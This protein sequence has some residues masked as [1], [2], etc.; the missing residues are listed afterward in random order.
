MQPVLPASFW[1]LF[2]RL[3]F[4]MLI[5]L[6]A[7]QYL[8]QRAARTLILACKCGWEHFVDSFSLTVYYIENSC[9]SKA[10]E[11]LINNWYVAKYF[12][13]VHYSM[14]IHTLSCEN[15]KNKLFCPSKYLTLHTFLSLEPFLQ[16]YCYR[17]IEFL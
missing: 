1:V 17:V 15:G 14:T 4:F 3:I 6:H 12:D 8:L 10:K 2:F 16:G 13:Q 11:S 7:A 5:V 9:N